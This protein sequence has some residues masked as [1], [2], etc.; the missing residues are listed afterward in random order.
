MT[1]EQLRAQADNNSKLTY[2]STKKSFRS[3]V[4][5]GFEDGPYK[6]AHMVRLHNRSL[7]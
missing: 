2:T 1:P 6:T 7:R 3:D 5:D 4:L